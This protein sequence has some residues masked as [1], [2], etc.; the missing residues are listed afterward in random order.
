[1]S[2]FSIRQMSR[3]DLDIAIAWAQQEGWRPGIFDADHYYPTDTTGFFLG[4]L[5]D[6]PIACISAVKYDDSFGF[7]GFYIVKPEYRHQGYGIQLWRQ[8]M[9]YLAGCNIGLDGVVAEQANY[10]KSGFV[11]AYRNLRYQ[12]INHSNT[13]PAEISA[14]MPLTDVPFDVL[15]AYDRLHFPAPRPTFLAS[16]RQQH[17]GAGLACYNGVT[18]TGY[19]VIRVCD[20]G[21]RVGPL[22][23]D[24]VEQAQTLLA[25]L[26]VQIPEGA[27]FFIDMPEPN[28][29]ALALVNAWE[30]QPV[31]ETARMYTQHNPAVAI[32]QIF[33]VTTLELG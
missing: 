15:Q 30:M 1:M 26:L 2:S 29:D 18:L 3:S 25:G 10:Q 7:I 21:Y 33:A 20:G 31:F 8:A 5:G 22:F 17:E 11:T 13:A 32:A 19:G 9:S 23:A 27:A 6:E 4:V 24:G 14:L 28:T 12:G 16:W